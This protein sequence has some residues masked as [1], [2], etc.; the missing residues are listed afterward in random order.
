[1]GALS[2]QHSNVALQ[3][4]KAKQYL[5]ELHKVAENLYK[6]LAVPFDQLSNQSNKRIS[7]QTA[8]LQLL[9]DFK[10]ETT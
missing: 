2:L 3:A 7:K 8:I 5:D 1:M 9:S 4:V 10:Q 6:L